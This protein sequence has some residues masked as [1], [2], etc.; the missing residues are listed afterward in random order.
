MSAT[1]NVIIAGPD[2]SKLKDR[3]REEATRR[4]QSVSEFCVEA[5]AEFLRRENRGERP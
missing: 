2:G 3:I 5:I 1:L 4:G